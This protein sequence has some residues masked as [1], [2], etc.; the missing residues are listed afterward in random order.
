M[1]ADPKSPKF[2][3]AYAQTVQKEPISTKCLR[4]ETWD[5]IAQ[6]YDDLEACPDY[7]H[8]VQTVVDTLKNQ[9]LTN[10]S[11]VIDVAC[12]TGNYA[13]RLAPFCKKVVALDISPGM[14]QELKKKMERTG[15]ENIEIVNQDWN[16]FETEE[17]FDLVFGSMTPILGSTEGIKRFLQLSRRYVAIVFWAGIRENLLLQELYKEIIGGT[18]KKKGL[19]IILPFN[20]IY[21]LGYAPE[22]HFFRGCWEKRRKTGEQVKNL[23]WRLELYRKLTEPEKQIVK[24]RIESKAD[25][26]GMVSVTTRVRTCFMLIDKKADHF[27]CE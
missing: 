27:T 7:M 26:Q 21:S 2:W 24:E 17:R 5:S 22:L 3:E 13:I 1:E 23:V 16:R 6:Y 25:S 11:T 15:I 19:D 12:G 9:V 20:Y 10:K 4:P 14:L 18:L 8:Q